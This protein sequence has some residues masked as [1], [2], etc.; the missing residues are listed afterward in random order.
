VAAALADLQRL[1]AFY[2]LLGSY[3]VAE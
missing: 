3:P 2:K 1:S